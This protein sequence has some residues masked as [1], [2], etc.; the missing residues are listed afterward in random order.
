MGNTW[1][2]ICSILLKVAS[3]IFRAILHDPAMY[4]EPDLFKPERFINQ[5]GSLRDDP[6]LTMAFGSGRRICP[7]RHL[8]DATFF[9]IVAS[10]LSVF[11]ITKG[12]DEDGKLAEYSYTG[13]F[14][15]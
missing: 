12:K 2:R 11:C 13:D 8:F 7:G 9:I 10:L 1:Y 3:F 14:I 6:T 4:P 15:R 5:D